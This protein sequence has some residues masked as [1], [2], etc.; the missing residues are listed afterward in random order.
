MNDDYI[1]SLSF[2]EKTAFVKLFC[3]M[4]NADKKIGDEEISFLKTI[5]RRYGIEN[6]M[7]VSIIK[8]LNNIELN[9]EVQKISSRQHAL[10]L[11][12][13]LCVLA[14][15]D[16]ELHDNE[17]ELIVDV[18]NAA[19]IEDEKIILINRFVLDSMVLN[20]AGNIILEQ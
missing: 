1:N 16:D 2:E 13:E 6:A 19:N 11:I 18:A 12:K 9:K 3:L 4:V 8:N 10:Q 17:L 14:N 5:A 15:I 20:K 7:M